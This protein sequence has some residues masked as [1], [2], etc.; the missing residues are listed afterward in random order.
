[1][2]SGASTSRPRLRWWVGSAIVAVLFVTALAFLTRVTAESH[3]DLASL[4]F[5]API[6]WVAQDQGGT[7]PPTYPL[8]VRMQSPWAHPT[9]IEPL[10][11]VANVIIIF[12]LV[13]GAVWFG[14][15][16]RARSRS[17]QPAKPR[18]PTTQGGR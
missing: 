9:A 2:V 3:D 15:W 14:A 11:F 10:P 13:I 8:E 6:A 1:M 7:D 4:R 18:D 17:D 5:G 12:A 16:L